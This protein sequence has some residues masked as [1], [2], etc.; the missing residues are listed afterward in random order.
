M[1]PLVEFS[2]GYSTLFIMKHSLRSLK[3]KSK[4]IFNVFR[5]KFECSTLHVSG[6]FYIFGFIG[7][8]L[9]KKIQLRYWLSG[10]AGR[11][12]FVGRTSPFRIK[13]LLYLFDQLSILYNSRIW[14]T[15]AVL[16]EFLGAFSL[17]G[18][19]KTLTGGIFS[20]RCENEIKIL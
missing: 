10:T 17:L 3:F 19:E 18:Y 9:S 5:R 14:R 2:I 11:V 15:H 7:I 16:P 12:D 13:L 6:Y 20:L 8:V 4:C 1:H